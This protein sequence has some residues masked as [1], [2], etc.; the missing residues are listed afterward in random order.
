MSEHQPT[1]RTTTSH[2]ARWA[3]PTVAALVVAGGIGYGTV[4]AGAADGLPDKSAEEILTGLQQASVPALSGTVVAKADLGL[5]D[6]PGMSDSA[7]LTSL[8]SGSHTMRVW[9]DGPEKVRLAKLGDAGE[10][11]IVR[12]GSQAWVWSSTEKKA[13]QYTLPTDTPSG[14]THRSDGAT[15]P[16]TPQEASQQILARLGEDS[17]VSTTSVSRVAGRD[18]YELV[19][20]PKQKDT[21][22]KDVRLAVDGETMIPLRVQ[23]FST[24]LSS[25]A[26]EV[27]FSSIDM[28]DVEDRMF[29]FTPPAGTTLEKQDLSAAGATHDATKPHGAKGDGKTTGDAK[30]EAKAE[31]KRDAKDDL[32]VVGQ[33]WSRVYV[34]NLGKDALAEMTSGDGESTGPHGDAAPDLAGVLDSL[35]QTSGAWGSGR[36]LD[37]TLFSAVLTDD[38]RVAVGA[39]PSTQLTAALATRR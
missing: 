18:A 11:D 13:V 2:R 8:V 28:G 22:V 14:Q 25:P 26:Y 9:Y 30:A 31:A 10:T 5:P 27:G 15:M 1:A 19:L 4:G 17:T 37:G 7:E 16:A 21:L 34:A 33:G 32:Q 39:V 38:G 12:N 35:P 3:V 23:V 36:V 6:M 24:R 20:T 29:T